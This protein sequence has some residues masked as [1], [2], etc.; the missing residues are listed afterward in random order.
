[1]TN[2]TEGMKIEPPCVVKDMPIEVYHNDTPGISSSQLV[3][4][5]W[6]PGLY[7]G[8]YVTKEYPGLET[9]ALEFGKALDLAL[10][11]PDRFGAMVAVKPEGMKFSTKEGKAWREEF[12]NRIIITVEE[13]KTIVNLKAKLSKKKI[14][15]KIFGDNVM[16]LSYFWE[17]PVEIGDTVV[18]VLCKCRPDRLSKHFISD[19]KS[20]ISPG[21][22]DFSKKIGNLNYHIKAAMYATGIN[23]VDGTDRGFVFNVYGKKPPYAIK[24]YIL[25]EHELATGRDYFMRGL[26][27]LLICQ[28]S[29]IWPDEVTDENWFG[30]LDNGIW[31]DFTDTI[32]PIERTAWQ[33]RND[34]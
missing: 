28:N 10:T 29:N 11:T 1:M 34:M 7:Y 12:R 20:D 27:T 4:L 32:E 6:S 17:Q 25:K 26:Q 8:R 24:F 5:I 30:F 14:A 22:Q 33:Q 18:K 15:P 19:D 9:A 23:T 21:Y 2:Y 13:H 31:H 3:D 16:Q